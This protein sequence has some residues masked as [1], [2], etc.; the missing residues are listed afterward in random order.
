M[1]RG[2]PP[3]LV[4]RCLLYVWN[5][6]CECRS[7]LLELYLIFERLISVLSVA[8]PQCSTERNVF[9]ADRLLNYII[10]RSVSKGLYNR[11]VNHC[12]PLKILSQGYR[13]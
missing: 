4:C 3:S 2:I 1:V 8:K 9:A 11:D 12:K 6:V 5:F 13:A 10:F 7:Q